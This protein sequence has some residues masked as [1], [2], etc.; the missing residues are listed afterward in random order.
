MAED[1][2]EDEE[3]VMSDISTTLLK[4]SSLPRAM[5]MRLARGR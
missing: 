4:L 5:L 3:S 2:M 1:D